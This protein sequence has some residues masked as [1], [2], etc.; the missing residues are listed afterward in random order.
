VVCVWH[1]VGVYSDGWMSL[2]E[3]VWG[4]KHKYW[5]LGSDVI[6]KIQQN[7]VQL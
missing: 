3:R 2:T 5:S 1:S 7:D 6:S 4:D